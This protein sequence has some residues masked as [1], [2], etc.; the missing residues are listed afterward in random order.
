MLNM[1]TVAE[2]TMAV[3]AIRKANELM[4]DAG[5]TW[6]Q[7]L[8]NK[9]RIIEDPFKNLATP[10][11]PT[12]VSAATAYT[13]TRSSTTPPKP[14][15]PPPPP[16]KGSP[17]SPISSTINRYVGWCW[18]CGMETVA[19]AGFIFKPTPTSTGWEV[20][21]T[22]CNTSATVYPYRAGRVKTP[23]KKSVSDLA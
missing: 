22:P 17:S 1:T 3:V 14:A 13:P 12:T 8:T 16:A 19:N 10:S 23:R 21:C 18:C 9:I 20:I 5:W 7:L 4:R 15:P 11:G 2:D 6:E